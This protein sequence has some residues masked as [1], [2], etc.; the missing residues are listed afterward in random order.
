VSAVNTGGIDVPFLIDETS[1][2]FHIAAMI[3]AAGYRA[4][5]LIYQAS[6]PKAIFGGIQDCTKSALAAMHSIFPR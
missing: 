5:S 2:D 4:D 6:W 1:N 3:A